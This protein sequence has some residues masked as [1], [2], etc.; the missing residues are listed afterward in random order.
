MRF[1]RALLGA[2][3]L[4]SVLLLPAASAAAT[5]KLE[6]TKSER[7]DPRLRELTMSTPALDFPVTVRVLLPAGYR[8]KPHRSY[9]VLYLLH[10]SFDTSASWTTKGDAE[11]I[12]AGKRLIV[13]MPPAAGKG[14]AGGWASDWRNEGN[15]GP[16]RWETFTISQLIPWVDSHLRTRANRKG[17]AI[18]GLSMGGFSA[19]SYAARHPDLFA[20]ASSFSGAVDTNYALSWPVIQAEALADGGATPD[21]IWGPRLTDEVFWRGHN[22]WDLASNL[23][24]MKLSIHTGNGTPGPYDSNPTP[25]AI[26]YGVH[27]MSRIFHE[28]LDKLGIANSY[29]DYG[30]GTH[31]WPYWQRDLRE[32]L[33]RIMRT[34]KHPAPRPSPFSYRSVEPSY[35]VYGWHV[36]MARKAAEWS[37]LRRV[38]RHSFTV[39]GS[40]TATVRTPPRF[41]PRSSHPIRIGDAKGTVRAGNDGRLRIEVRLGPANAGQEYRAG[42]T[43]RTYSQRVHIGKAAGG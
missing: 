17:R 24:G 9:P 39:R 20:W 35:S 40:G 2:A 19:M 8:R 10:G 11:K 5:N 16:P 32:D 27:D 7:L 12:T 1:R 26:E 3:L 38:G 28:R 18:A 21:S 37:E 23:A 31:S 36:S 30:P 15:F 13:V 14:N 33:P 4:A 25:D 6:L 22:P 34:F 41:V 29:D 43:T 42:V